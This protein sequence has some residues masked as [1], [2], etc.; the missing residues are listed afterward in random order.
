MNSFW[1]MNSRVI[2]L[3]TYRND[4]IEIL[5]FD[6]RHGRNNTVISILIISRKMET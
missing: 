3:P 4:G 1:A 2:S 5:F 6:E